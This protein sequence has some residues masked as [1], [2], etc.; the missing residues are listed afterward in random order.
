MPER[1]TAAK[2]ITRRTSA[3]VA[4]TS[5]ARP[6]EAS[7]KRKPSSRKAAAMIEAE[8][9]I[10]PEAYVAALDSPRREIV[11]RLRRIIRAAAPKAKESIKWGQPVFEQK[12]LL[13]FV[14][15]HAA[16]VNLGFYIAGFALSDPD[17]MLE[18]T[19]E[20]MRHVKVRAVSEIRA[21]LFAAWVR[22]AVEFN[23]DA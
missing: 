4:Q 9:S 7:V 17:K 8:S 18:G 19:G 12:G 14:A 16:H 3:T 20:N 21:G 15:A 10:S 13:C 2:P 5:A 22:T 23:E 1:R 6:A 11:E